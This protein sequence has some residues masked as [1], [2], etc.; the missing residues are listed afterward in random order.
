L[1]TS[2]CVDIIPEIDLLYSDVVAHRNKC[3]VLRDR[4]QT[5]EPTLRLL[6]NVGD[7]SMVLGMVVSFL[8]ETLSSSKAFME[9]HGSSAW[10]A[11]A[12]NAQRTVAQYKQL[13]TS[14]DKAVNDLSSFIAGHENG[15]QYNE[16]R[17]SLEDYQQRNSRWEDTM[18]DDNEK[19]CKKV[20]LMQ[21]EQ[22]K[23]IRDY[24]IG[25]DKITGVPIVRDVMVGINN[26][27]GVAV[28]C[29]WQNKHVMVKGFRFQNDGFQLASSL[30]RMRHPNI[31]KIVG[32]YKDTHGRLHLLTAYAPRGSLAKAIES[33]K[34]GGWVDKVR[35]ALGIAQGMIYLHCRRPNISHGNLKPENVV[36]ANDGHP[37]LVDYGLPALDEN[38]AHRSPSACMFVAPEVATKG[39]QFDVRKADVFS[40]GMLLWAIFKE[41][42]PSIL[43]G[44]ELPAIPQM[45]ASVLPK[46]SQTIMM[47]WRKN[48]ADRPDFTT[49]TLDLM[50]LQEHLTR[51]T[52]AH[53]ND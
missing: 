49:L 9:L 38:A 36:F 45:W 24:H 40:F 4:V 51:S 20:C 32:V 3:T 50:D 13:N 44:G 46:L 48:P 41:Q 10:F 7:S 23:L 5:L 53:N 28:K 35:V 34:M 14:L 26:E 25:R 52:G 33:R 47:C 1:V 12:V 22:Q 30:W 37:L 43:A 31:S 11:N 42:Q 16:L 15:V 2:K 6:K 39:A 27:F 8:F 18:T 29:L 17:K 21:E 19:D